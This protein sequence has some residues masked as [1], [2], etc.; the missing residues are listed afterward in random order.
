MDV[1]RQVARGQRPKWCDP[2]R[3][4]GAKREAV[5]EQCG[6][7]F[8]GWRKAR[9]CSRNCGNAS[10]R[11]QKPEQVL[12]IPIDQR[13]PLRRAFEERDADTFFAAL[14]N[15][16][17]TSGDCWVWPRLDRSGYPSARMGKKYVALHRIVLEMKHGAALGS[18]HA[19]HTCANSA[20]V[21]PD[22]LQPVTHRENVA[23]MLARQSYLRRIRDLEAALTEASPG[24][25]LLSVVAIA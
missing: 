7:T 18:Q 25:P 6:S 21:N 10:R 12:P 11:K 20:C 5:C 24:H 2:C 17:D 4:R 13:R 16:A 8:W 22:H 3:S 19:H 1:V 15:E 14:V 23:E 9:Y